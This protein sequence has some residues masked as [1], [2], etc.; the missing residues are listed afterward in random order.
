M[1]LK[2]EDGHGCAYTIDDEGTLYYIPLTS[3]NNLNLD[4]LAEVDLFNMDEDDR[5]D[6]SQIHNDLIA[7][8]KTAAT[9]YQN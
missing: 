4:E 2:L 5:D 9:Y 6:V 1:I 3:K 7:L 8:A